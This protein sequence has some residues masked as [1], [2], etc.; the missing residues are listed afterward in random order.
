MNT[1]LIIENDPQLTKERQRYI[2]EFLETWEGDTID[3][4]LFT[5]KSKLEIFEAVNK[6]T[7]IITQ[8]CFVNGSDVQFEG[9]IR[10]LAN[11]PQHKTIYIAYLGGDL[12]DYMD[13]NMSDEELISIKH[14]T[15]CEYRYKED[16]SKLEVIKMNFFERINAHFARIEAETNYTNS[17][18]SRTTGRKVKILACNAAGNAFKGLNFGGVVDEL[19][20]TTTDPNKDR[21]VWIWGNGEPIKLVN[22]CRL[23]EYEIVSEIDYNSFISEIKKCTPLDLN[24]LKLSEILGIMSIVEDE[25]IGAMEAANFICE[26]TGTAKRENRRHIHNLIIKYRETIFSTAP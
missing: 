9:M 24:D 6:C 2:F 20:M 14:H 19:D 16:F 7:H 10:L 23:Q 21:G 26:Q 13:R 22:D 3:F 1:L 25:E 12:F 11:V 4:S 17:A 15:V 8:T 18:Q 5:Q